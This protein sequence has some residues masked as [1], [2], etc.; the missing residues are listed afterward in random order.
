MLEFSKDYFKREVRCGFAVGEVMKHVWAAELEM[1]AEIIRVCEKYELTYYV[2][3][4][5]LLGAV[6]HQGFIPWDDDIDIALVGED[7][8]RFLEVAG[9]ELPAAYEIRN[10]YTDTRWGDYFT[11]INNNTIVDISP[12]HM[13]KYHGCP[14]VVGMDV[15]PLYYLPRDKEFAEQQ[16]VVLDKIFHAIGYADYQEEL[17]REGGEPDILET[18]VQKL[19]E[20]M[21][22][23]QHLTGYQFN[24]DLPIRT[25]LYQLYDQVGRLCQEDESDEVTAFWEYRRNGYSV[26]KELLQETIK[27]PFE[28]LMVTA[29]AGYDEILKKTFG[30]YMTPR[31]YASHDYPFFQ[32]EAKLMGGKV[33]V[34][35]MQY[36]MGVENVNLQI[37]ANSAGTQISSE[38]AK[39]MLPVEWWEKIYP[40]DEQGKIVRKKVILYYTDIGSILTHSESVAEKLRYVFDVFRSNPEVVLW[41]FPC[42]FENENFPYIHSM[43]PELLEEYRGIVEEYR[44]GEVGIYDDS[45]D[46]SRA[47]AMCDA[48]FG[49]EGFIADCVKK[50]G[51]VM[52]YQ[53]YQI[54]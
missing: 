6:R 14:L 49:D 5:S 35:D 40:L 36:K 9:R 47:I 2:Y 11:H 43:I 30:D 41:W 16:K 18:V 45:G 15:F 52:M 32:E 38:E 42:S 54:V 25:Q 19:A 48:Y 39:S 50:T 53:D 46:I 17:K 37:V 33:E 4:G 27:L 1:L 13:E 12:E 31:I 29:P 24:N 21:V 23:L 7:Y 44:R 3:W 28:N 8:V 51:K 34:M 26:R 22:E 20:G 10:M